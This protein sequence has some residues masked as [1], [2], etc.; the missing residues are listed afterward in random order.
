MPRADRPTNG[1]SNVSRAWI[2]G[3]LVLLGL[4]LTG[5]SANG[6]SA[7]ATLAA[8]SP[9]ASIIAAL[10]TP[11]PVLV[12]AGSAYQAAADAYNR[13]ATKLQ[14]DWDRYIVSQEMTAKV[15]AHYKAM[16]KAEQD[17]AAAVRRV[18]FP[19]LMRLHIKALLDAT[20]AAADLDL[21][22]SRIKMGAQVD[23]RAILA[24]ESTS[25]A[26][27]DIVRRDLEVL[28]YKP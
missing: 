9:R 11:D 18:A 25:A 2:A 5:C 22:A 17:F 28:G 7:T 24:A 21:K 3:L 19:A 15:L 13:A 26:A 12:Q 8:A 14:A 1:G 27:A 20:D 23:A 6:P 4:S 16:A 10:R